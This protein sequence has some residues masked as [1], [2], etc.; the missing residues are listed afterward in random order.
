MRV[1]ILECDHVGERN[2]NIA[3]DYSEMFRS[4]LAGPAPDAEV[5]LYDARS[6]QLPD[7]TRE[8]DGWLCTGSRASAYDD[9]EWIAGVSAF[10]R[11]AHDDGAP[12]V[13][14]CF[15]HQ[16]LAH[17]LGGRT[18]R[19]PSGWGVG[20]HSIDVKARERWMDPALDRPNLL[21]VH[22]D[23]VTRV[24]DD[25]V[26]LGS[27]D[28]CPVAMMRIGETMLGMQ[29]HPEFGPA[30]VEALVSARTDLMGADRAESALRSLSQ[31]TDEAVVAQWIVR[32]LE[33]RA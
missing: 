15:G 9:D 17:A 22:Q 31:A 7:S 12:F 18:E 27:T 20:A 32:F 30:Y 23:Q 26:V 11:E 2:R 14:I 21:F 16:L 8:C 3:G 19:A 4:M 29:A 25:G 10:M 6:G 13:G 5:V 28:H 33:H 1:G 24:P